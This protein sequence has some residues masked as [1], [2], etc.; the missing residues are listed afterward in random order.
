MAYTVKDI[1]N[2]VISADTT[3]AST[4]FIN[5]ITVNV[6]IDD[7]DDVVYLHF[8]G[9]VSNT[10]MDNA[11]TFRAA[12]GGSPHGE[13]QTTYCVTQDQA[14]TISMCR[15]ITGLTPGIHALNLE[16]KTAGGIAQIRPISAPGEAGVLKV[17]VVAR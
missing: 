1:Q 13:E 8:S 16:W 10:A 12:E 5:L 9:A 17:E 6:E 14:F 11:V 4:T 3:T 7:T 2:A 15:P